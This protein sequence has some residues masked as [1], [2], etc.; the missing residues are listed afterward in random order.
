MKIIRALL[1]PAVVLI[2]VV[3]L[4]TAFTVQQNEVAL[5]IRLGS[6]NRVVDSPG[7]HFRIPFLDEVQ[8]YEKWILDYDS[9]PREILTRDKKNLRVDNYAKWQITDP[10]RFYQAVKDVPGA[11]SRLDDIIYSE[12][13]RS[14]G[15]YS[16]D[17]IVKEKRQQVMSEVARNSNEQMKNLGIQIIDVRIKRADLPRENEGA[18]YQRMQTERMR[19]AKLYRSE[20]EENAR[21]IRAEADKQKQIILAEANRDAQETR[22]RADAEAIKIFAAAYNKDP[23]FFQF[24]RSLE[25]YRKSFASGTTLVLTPDLEL[26]QFFK[27]SGAGIPGTDRASKP[28][29]PEHA[30]K[31][32]EH[33]PASDAGATPSQPAPN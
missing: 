26:L 15:N 25:A 24:F 22:G 11:L 8:S 32:A 4:M 5:V 13:R 20:G 18:V 9:S 33:A 14:L 7:L 12:L 19:D 6:I 30:E 1:L 28:V 2:V 31:P 10:K 29:P 21:K 23:E 16:L 27:N 3:L 17:E